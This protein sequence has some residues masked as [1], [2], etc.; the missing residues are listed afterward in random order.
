MERHRKQ[1]T[2]DLEQCIL[3]DVHKYR[4]IILG[5]G[6]VAGY[7]AKEFVENGLKAGELG[8]V[9]ADNALPYERPPLSKSFLA[10]KDNEESILINPEGF[11]REHGIGVQLNVEIARIDLPGK[12]LVDRRGDEFHFERLVLATGAEPRTL[13]VPGAKAENVLYL[14]S[15]ADSARLRDRLKSAKRVAVIGSGFIGMEV[16]S[17]SAQQ[18]R[19]TTMVFPEARVWKTFFTPEMS[20]FFQK[21]YEDRGVHFASSANVTSIGGSSVSLSTGRKLEADLVLAGVGVSPVTE[22]AEAAGLQVKNG[23]VVNEFLQTSA[24]N[25]Y[26][27]GDVANYDDVLFKKRR[28]VEHWDNAVKQGQYLARHLSGRQERFENIPYFFSDVFDLSYEFWGDTTGAERTE[29]RGDVHS[30][31]FSAWWLKGNQVVAAFA[32]NRPDAEREEAS[33]L[34]RPQ[35]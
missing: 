33:Q 13:D 7:A 27:A 29:Y 9:S 35:K 23:I 2:N 34:K 8:I 18:G 11:Y 3:M 24:G 22:L 15:V 4:D 1:E 10:G 32:M 14:R 17:Q 25:V 19:E 26:A 28:R 20:Q 31:S 21:Y 5:G 30:T 12:R 6:M 16:A